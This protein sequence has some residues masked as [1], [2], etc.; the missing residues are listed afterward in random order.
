MERQGKLCGYDNSLWISIVFSDK[1]KQLKHD[2]S[3]FFKQLSNQTSR[4]YDKK[5]NDTHWLLVTGV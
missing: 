4:K 5:I 3:S 2:C 1:N